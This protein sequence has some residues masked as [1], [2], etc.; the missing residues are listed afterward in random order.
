MY[1][2]L[3]CTSFL[4]VWSLLIKA[5][6]E[7]V[8][9]ILLNDLSKATSQFTFIE[10][11]VFADNLVQIITLVLVGSPLAIPWLKLTW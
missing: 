10:D 8:F 4:T 7:P 9:I 2:S 11:L 6:T 5:R 3:T 1:L